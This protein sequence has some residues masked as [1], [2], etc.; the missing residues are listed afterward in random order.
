MFDDVPIFVE[1]SNG[2]AHG[3]CIFTEEHRFVESGSVLVHPRHAGV[4][5]GIEVREAS[6]A[7]TVPAASAFVVYGSAVES[8]G[9]V[10]AGS[11]VFTVAC[12][13][14]KAPHDHGRMVSV[15]CHH[16][17]DSVAEGGNPGSAVA[18]SLVGMVF[19]VGFVADVET[20]EVIHCIEA[21]VVRIV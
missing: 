16:A 18:D 6:A 5:F 2:V 4:H 11:E 20:V 10:V 12:L 13:V 15:S 7:V 9:F 17:C 19:E 14:S 21:A 1:V 3:V 8:F